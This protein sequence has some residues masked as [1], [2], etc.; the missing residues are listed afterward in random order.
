MIGYLCSSDPWKQVGAWCSSVTCR[1]TMLSFLGG[2]AFSQGRWT[3]HDQP[4]R[5][6][7]IYHTHTH[8]LQSFQLLWR[9]RP[10]AVR[11]MA[12]PCC[13]PSCR[14]PT[15]KQLVLS[16]CVASQSCANRCKKE[17]SKPQHNLLAGSARPATVRC[18][19][20]HP[21]TSS[22]QSDRRQRCYASDLRVSCT[23]NRM[24]GWAAQSGEGS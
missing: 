22:N 16:N 5:H 14:S 23:L 9:R 21:A 20:A 12:V 18:K 1:V 17:G 15:R 8:N 2:S 4:A 19:T 13:L 7:T 11:A 10:L 6:T 3:L 24:D